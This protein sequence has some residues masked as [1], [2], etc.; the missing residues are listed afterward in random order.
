MLCTIAQRR[1]AGF[2][3]CAELGISCALIHARENQGKRLTYVEQG[4]TGSL[5][6]ALKRPA[7]EE[8]WCR[9]VPFPAPPAPRLAAAVQAQVHRCATSAATR[10]G[11]NRHQSDWRKRPRNRKRQW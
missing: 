2:A 1:L 11:R 3:K 7:A 10:Q 9:R 5:A 6:L 8:V 4:P